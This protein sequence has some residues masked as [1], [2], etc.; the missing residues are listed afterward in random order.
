MT[1]TADVPKFELKKISLVG[2]WSWTLKTDT[3]GICKEKLAEKCIECCINDSYTSPTCDLVLGECG[4]MFHVHCIKP[5]IKTHSVCP[6]CNEP[7]AISDK[8][9]EG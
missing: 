3:C 8:N 5:W 1:L 7:W 2:T 9:I 4:H 6:S